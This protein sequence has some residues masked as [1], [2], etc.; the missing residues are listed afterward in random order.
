MF[1]IQPEVVYDAGAQLSFVSTAGI[2]FLMDV[3]EKLPNRKYFFLDY[4]GRGVFPY[5]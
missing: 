2:L 3:E 5:F 4:L 1:L